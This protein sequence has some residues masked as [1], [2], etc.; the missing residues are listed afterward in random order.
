MIN[1]VSKYLT[2]ELTVDE[3][4]LFLLSVAE[5]KTL[6][7]ELAEFDQLLG[8]LS[9]LPQK[10]DELKAQKSLLNFLKDIDTKKERE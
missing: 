10:D 9:L 2:G 4:K 8:H 5:D 7:D 6:R 3:K 1:L